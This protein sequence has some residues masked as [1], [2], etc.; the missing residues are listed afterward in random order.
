[1]LRITLKS[2]S[3][4]SFLHDFYCVLRAAGNPVDHPAAGQKIVKLN[5]IW[6]GPARLGLNLD[7]KYLMIGP[8]EAI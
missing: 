6:A 5:L 7:V 1:M 3:H 8:A 4:Q 2:I